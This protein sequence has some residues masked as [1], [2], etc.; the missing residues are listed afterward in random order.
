MKAA[1]L[2]PLVKLLNEP[3]LVLTRRSR[4]LK[5]HPGQIS[6][7]GGYIEPGE[8]PLEAALRETSEE[9]G[10]TYGQLLFVKELQT[11][12]TVTTGVAVESFLGF[13]SEPVFYV[14]KE[15]VEDLIFVS[16]KSLTKPKPEIVKMPSGKETIRYRLDGLIIWGATARIIESA[17]E[18][19]DH[20]LEKG[21][22]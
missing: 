16:L 3:F 18:E 8:T 11:S 15:E 10:I 5:S 14:N 21:Q 13:L 6:F 1:V 7:P 17:I 20:I 4:H 19:I 12:V 9:I 22:A 2:I